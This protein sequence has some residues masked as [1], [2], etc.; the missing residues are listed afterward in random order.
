MSVIA[1]ALQAATEQLRSASPT[2]RLDAEILLAHVNGITRAA[3]LA[4]LTDPLAEAAQARFE[5]LVER[6][7]DGEPIAYLTG[8]R[9]F[10][11]LSF[12]V[13]R[14]VLVPRPET[15]LLVEAA[16]RVSA[17]FAERDEIRIADIGV[18]SGAIAVA[19]AVHL[20]RARVWA[21]D[22]SPA[23]LDVA[24]ANVRRHGV[25]QR[26]ILL[27]GNSL[28]AL[29]GPVDLLVSNP[30]Y[31]VL[32]EVDDNVRRH[33]PHLALDGGPAGLDV[34]RELFASAP[35]FLRGGVMLV[36]IGAWQGDAVCAMARAAFP[37]GVVTVHRDL[38]GLDRVVEVVVEQGP[39][40]AA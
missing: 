26:V 19:L 38:A 12:E 18:G 3:L 13:D 31:T 9:E 14:R 34:I 29:P 17:R 37:D 27:Q 39:N 7:R 22:L 24:R 4:R 1:S 32:A 25:A 35:R 2:A 30:P 10:F 21:V 33:E 11:G 15:E 23:A 5:Q 40:N 28:A 20:P 8:E 16:L 36:E 6:R